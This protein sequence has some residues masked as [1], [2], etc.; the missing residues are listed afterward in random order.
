MPS[1]LDPV[2]CPKS[3]MVSV[4]HRTTC[5]YCWSEIVISNHK[6][7]ACRVCHLED[8][9]SAEICDCTKQWPKLSKNSEKGTFSTTCI[10]STGNGE[11]TIRSTN[12]NIDSRLYFDVEAFQQDISIWCNN[13]NIFEANETSRVRR[14]QCSGYRS[15]STIFPLFGTRSLP[16]FSAVTMVLTYFP[17]FNS[18]STFLRSTTRWVNPASLVSSLP[19]DLQM[20]GCV[21]TYLPGQG[22]QLQMTYS[23][24]SFHSCSSPPL[25]PNEC[26]LRVLDESGPRM[27]DWRQGSQPQLPSISQRRYLGHPYQIWIAMTSLGDRPIAGRV[28]PPLKSVGILW[29]MFRSQVLPFCYHYKMLLPHYL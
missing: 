12:E 18:L 19:G 9:V 3:C 7:S 1:H 5:S 26:Y 28:I 13:W 20:E 16:L 2:R 29:K 25:S 4:A 8:H 22:A 21:G 27:D 23:P 24:T 11:Q 14:K 6:T 15:T 10:L 17:S